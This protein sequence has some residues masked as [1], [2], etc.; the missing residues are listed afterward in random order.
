MNKN[1]HTDFEKLNNNLN[2]FNAMEGIVS[3]A[4]SS[5]LNEDFFKQAKEYI[6]YVVQKQD[7]SANQAVMLALVTEHSYGN[8]RVEMEGIAQFV[9]C[10][11]IKVVQFQSDMDELVKKGILY[12]CNENYDT[13]YLLAP[14]AMKAFKNDEKFEKESY[15]SADAIE[16][17]Q[18]FFDLTHLLHEDML[19]TELFVPEFE[20]MLQENMHIPYV[21]KLQDPKYR[22]WDKIILTQLCRHLVLN[23]VDDGV[24]FPHIG[25]LEDDRNKRFA[26]CND[27]KNGW[28]PLIVKGLLEHG[29]TNGFENTDVVRLTDKAKS[30]LLAGVKITVQ[31]DSLQDVTLCQDISAKELFFCPSVQ[32]Q[33]GNLYDM[34]SEERY[35][36]ICNRLKEHG[37]RQGFTC[38]FY[39]A[40]GTGKT[41]TVLQLARATGRDVMHVNVSDIK[42]KWVGESEKNIKALFDQYRNI[43]KTR[44]TT[45]ILLFNEADAIIGKRKEGA[46]YAVDKMEN[47]IQNIIL[48]EMEKLEGIMIATTNLVQNMD[49]AFER[50]FLYKVRFEKPDT[51]QRS[52]IWLSMLPKLSEGLVYK[53]ANTYDFSGGQIE[54][55]ARKCDIESI[56]YGDEYLTD[57]RVEE[58]CR[59]ETICQKNNGRRIGFIQ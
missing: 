53:L 24:D 38:L 32:E 21:Q 45:P 40:P 52:R 54:N 4:V 3:K 49:G 42:S 28:H 59:Q 57:S 18:H 14:R 33:L 37:M 43:V 8:K 44:K 31:T 13:G 9:E 51:E 2:M 55:I 29:C 27:L 10:R 25:F 12:Y 58:Y 1:A 36:G 34:L 41:E 30:E 39:G 22:L 35:Q 56:L 5:G 46:D 7:I 17:F 23:G 48:Q 16:F 11:N 15:V 50:R 47:S 20:R 19:S 6:D 26:L